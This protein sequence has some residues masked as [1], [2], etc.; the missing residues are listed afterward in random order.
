MSMFKFY[1]YVQMLCLCSNVVSM[2]ECFVF[3][4]NCCVYINICPTG[5]EEARCDTVCEDQ[6]STDDDEV[7]QVNLFYTSRRFL[8]WVIP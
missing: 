1:I 5:S 7:R 6:H 8:G 2:F 3:V 4:F